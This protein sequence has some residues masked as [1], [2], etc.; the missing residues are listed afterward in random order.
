M[1]LKH[2]YLGVL[3]DINLNDLRGN[4]YSGIYEVNDP[5]VVSSYYNYPNDN[6]VLS[7]Y[8][9][10]SVNDRS[11]IDIVKENKD[12]DPEMYNMYLAYTHSTEPVCTGI[13][14]ISSYDKLTVQTF[15]RLPDNTVFTRACKDDIWSDWETQMTPIYNKI[16]REP[17]GKNLWS[18]NEILQMCYDKIPIFSDRYLW[19]RLNTKM[20]RSSFD[21]LVWRDRPDVMNATCTLSNLVT[22]N[23]NFQTHG[24]PADY[25]ILYEKAWDGRNEGLHWIFRWN[26]NGNDTNIG[27]DSDTSNLLRIILHSYKNIFIQN[28]DGSFP[29]GRLITRNE[30]NFQQTAGAGHVV[31]PARPQF[32]LHVYVWNS[33]CH[34]IPGLRKEV[35]IYDTGLD[36]EN[37]WVRYDGDRTITCDRGGWI[38]VNWR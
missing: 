33:V 8:F 32:D 24:R 17:D 25:G 30:W 13:L 28:P 35:S 31:L 29:K 34:F 15:T 21:R 18:Y 7:K 14:E 12:S 9:L 6:S 2:G 20:L 5:S 11:V 23:I 27:N 37:V 1:I 10:R 16:L 38:H 4:Q 26:W 3:K 36:R 22:S 19:D